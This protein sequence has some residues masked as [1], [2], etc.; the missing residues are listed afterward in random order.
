MGNKPI[1]TYRS[2]NISGAIWLN[3]K[4]HNGTT[5]EFKTASI[6]RSWHDPEKDIWRDESMNLRRQDI[7]KVMIILQK[8]QEELYLAQGD[9]HDE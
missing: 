2:G 8:I 3:V 1:Q 9:E 6:R 5:T 4:E 7:P